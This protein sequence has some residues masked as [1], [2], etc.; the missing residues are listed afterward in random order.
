MTTLNTS[1]DEL[2]DTF[3]FLDAWE[4]KYGFIIDL[5]KQLPALA[6]EEM[7]DAF[8]VRGCQAQVWLVPVIGQDGRITF[9]ANSDAHIQRGL[10]AIML[11]IFSGKT[12][13]EILGIDA[14]AILEEMDLAAHLTAQR[15]NGLF[16]MVE[17]IREI[18]ASFQG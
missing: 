14:R 2:M 15:A 17:R 12:P 16:S 3:A 4:D 7:V 5:G 18:A 10:V 8:K 11:L 1:L 6:P 13:D 9:R